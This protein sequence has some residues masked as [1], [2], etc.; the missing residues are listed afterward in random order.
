M[1]AVDSSMCRR[2]TSIIGNSPSECENGVAS[3]TG[4]RKLRFDQRS[5]PIA[6]SRALPRAAC[7]WQP[8]IQRRF[9]M[10]LIRLLLAALLAVTASPASARPDAILIF[11]HTTGWRHDSIPA[12]IAA[13]T[14]IAK[15]RGLAVVA[16]KDPAAFDPGRLDRFRAIV[17]LST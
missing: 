11:S 1:A 15:A 9:A 3:S 10:H 7:P 5:P 6:Q 17:L 8:A 2:E 14:A 13:V 4:A 16:S 12:G